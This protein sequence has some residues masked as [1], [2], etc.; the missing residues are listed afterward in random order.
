[1]KSENSASLRARR[2]GEG[3][4]CFAGSVEGRTLE[5]FALA[6]RTHR[7][8][9]LPMLNKHFRFDAVRA[10]D[11]LVFAGGATR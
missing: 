3:E 2:V 8:L 7:Q 9:D 11:D 4:F 6:G 1:V 10:L 5:I